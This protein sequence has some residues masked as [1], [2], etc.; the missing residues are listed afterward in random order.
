MLKGGVGSPTA[1]KQ[2]LHFGGS[3]EN[4]VG[5]FKKDP[6]GSVFRRKP[7]SVRLQ[8]RSRYAGDAFK[9]KAELNETLVDNH[10]MTEANA[11]KADDGIMAAIV[12]APAKAEEVTLASFGKFKVNDS[13]ARD[14]C[15]PSTGETLQIAASKRFSLVPAKAVTDAL[16]RGSGADTQALD[17]I[18][19]GEK[20]PAEA[21]QVDVAICQRL[22]GEGKRVLVVGDLCA[23][24]ALAQL[25]GI[26]VVGRLARL[27][28]R[29]FD[30]VDVEQ[31]RFRTARRQAH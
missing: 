7:Q 26:D 29:A 5:Q 9:N 8:G 24:E 17:E 10:A 13:P 31:G 25:L 11:R 14:G 12:A 3:I 16:K 22:L 2:E 19:I 1:D 23:G 27:P 28:G 6:E 30:I 20:R 18:G 4:A 21:V 15:N